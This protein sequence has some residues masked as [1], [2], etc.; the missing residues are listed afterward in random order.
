NYVF[1]GAG[2]GSGAGLLKLVANGSGVKEEWVYFK[3]ELN[4]RHGG[5]V[6]LGDYVYADKDNAGEPFCARWETGAIQWK[7]NGKYEGRG[8]VSIVYA[9]RRLYMHYDNGYVALVEASPKAY[10]EHG[11]FKIPNSANNSWAHPVVVGGKLYLREKEILWC[12]DVR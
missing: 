7:R 3:R 2:Y 11:V 5:Y 9:D 12:Y 4:S 1:A 10:K 8:S 6:V